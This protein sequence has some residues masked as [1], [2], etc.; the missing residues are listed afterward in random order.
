MQTPYIFG[1]F[2]VVVVPANYPMGSMENP[3]LVFVS[4]TIFTT[5]LPTPGYNSVQGYTVI[6]AV[7]HSW[8]GDWVNA[9]NWADLWI[10][11][12]FAVFCERHV[13]D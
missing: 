13:T 8:F 11:E 6:H 5:L 7:C 10:N 3:M 2:N 1:Q 9:N 12:G 4:P